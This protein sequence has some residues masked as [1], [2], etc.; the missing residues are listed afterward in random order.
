M[1]QVDHPDVPEIKHWRGF[2]TFRRAEA[3]VAHHALL[4][5]ARGCPVGWRLEP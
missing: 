1:A 2:P 5:E 3:V 4:T